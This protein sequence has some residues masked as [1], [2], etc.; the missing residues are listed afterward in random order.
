MNLHRKAVSK[1]MFISFKSCFTKALL[2]ELVKFLTYLPSEDI[3][4]SMISPLIDPAGNSIKVL[5][6][7]C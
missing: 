3:N 1:Y 5:L 7:F 2:Y 6:H 4:S